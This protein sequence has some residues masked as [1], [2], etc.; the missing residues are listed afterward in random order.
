MKNVTPSVDNL[1]TPSKSQSD[2]SSGNNSLGL[3]LAM[4]RVWTSMV[5]MDPATLASACWL[6]SVW[7]K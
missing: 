1:D 5:T 2:L 3:Q 4:S 7:I 6:L